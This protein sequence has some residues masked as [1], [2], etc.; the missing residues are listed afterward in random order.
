[1]AKFGGYKSWEKISVIE[2]KI[3]KKLPFLSYF[4]DFFFKVMK[5]FLTSSLTRVQSRIEI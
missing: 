4:T 5:A 3:E 2:A 1:M